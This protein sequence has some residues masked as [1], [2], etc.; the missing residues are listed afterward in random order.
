MFIVDKVVQ[1]D[2]RMLF[3]NE[4]ESITLPDWSTQAIGPS[5]ERF[6]SSWSRAYSR[7]TVPPTLP[8]GVSLLPLTHPTRIPAVVLKS[9]SCSQHSELLHSWQHHFF[10]LLLKTLSE[11]SAFPLA[12][13]GTCV[14]F[15][16]LKQFSSELETEAEVIL[17][18]LIKLFIGES[19]TSE[20]RPG[21]MRVLAMEIMRG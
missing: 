4:L 17:T 12:L 2:R 20:P 16:L 7:T 11:R 21:W 10:P 15:L 18:L 9:L 5:G 14:N 6:L 8:Q 1:D 19:D 13:R 3:A